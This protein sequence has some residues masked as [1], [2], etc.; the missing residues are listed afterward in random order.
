ME[1]AHVHKEGAFIIPNCQWQSSCVSCGYY[2]DPV[3]EEDRASCADG[4][5]V[6]PLLMMVQER[7]D[8]TTGN[9]FVL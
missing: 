8:M 1:R 3:F 7:A 4:S 6:M 2:D 5:P 9:G